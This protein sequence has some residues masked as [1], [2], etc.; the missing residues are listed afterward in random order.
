ML[1]AGADVIL[2]LTRVT[3]ALGKD[4]CDLLRL[5]TTALSRGTSVCVALGLVR[6][7]VI[8]LYRELVVAIHCAFQ[9]VHQCVDCPSVR[10]CGDSKLAHQQGVHKKVRASRLHV[11][12]LHI[13]L[14]YESP[15]YAYFYLLCLWS[16]RAIAAAARR[17]LVSV[18]NYRAPSLKFSG[19]YLT[20]FLSSCVRPCSFC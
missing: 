8:I 6:S 3:E 1:Y 2:H 19:L 16:T 20:I 12:A 17:G 15:Q 13:I 9:R 5:A 14:I 7:G 18:L 4:H 11:G 10:L